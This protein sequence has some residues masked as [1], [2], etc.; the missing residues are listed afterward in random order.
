M[1][2]S[3]ISRKKYKPIDK[4]YQCHHNSNQA[5]STTKKCVKKVNKMKKIL[6]SFLLIVAVC[7]LQGSSA[8]AAG[9]TFVWTNANGTADMNDQANWTIGDAS[10][11]N[12]GVPG[13]NDIISFPNTLSGVITNGIAGNPHFKTMTVNMASSSGYSFTG[14]DFYVGQIFAGGSAQLTFNVPVHTVGDTTS[15]VV[16]ITASSATTTVNIPSALDIVTAPATL[17]GSGTINISGGISGAGDLNKNGV[18]LLTLSGVNS[19]T[20][21]TFVSGG[22]LIVTNGSGLGTTA[23]ST[24]VQSGASLAIVSTSPSGE[25]I[26]LNGTGQ[27][28]AG[29]EALSIDAGTGTMNLTGRITLNSSDVTIGSRSS[30]L[31]SGFMDGSGGFTFVDR[32]GTG[33][34]VLTLTSVGT[35]TG[36]T[37][38]SGPVTI[39]GNQSSS[40]VIVPSGATLKGRGTVGA[41]TVQSGGHVA[42]GNSPGCMSSG[43]ASFVNGSSFDVEL[44][45]NTVCTQY[46]QLNV[47]GTVDLG[48][49]TLN[50]ALVNGFAPVIGNSFTIINNDLADAVTGTFAGLPEG[51]TL[52][53]GS[54]VFKISYVGGTGNDIVLTV[55]DPST[56][57]TATTAAPKAPNTGLG[58]VAAHPMTTLAASVVAALTMATIARKIKPSTARSHR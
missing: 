6:A 58:L 18:G 36:S 30:L 32:S 29:Y 56:P 51:A 7:I 42:P 22:T 17:D 34:G 20:G 19:Y 1:S 9:I 35:Y 57:V 40:P 50:L 49:A 47:T 46:D 15:I 2:I 55:M 28:S 41:I 27:T 5:Y 25:N 12:D 11:G 14:N 21:A 53:V 37:I 3:E 44:G 48:G 31:I 33:N 26:V 24:T 4:C 38:I 54:T 16:G 52:K 39:D 45:G 23:G 43:N 13:T 10:P 8:S